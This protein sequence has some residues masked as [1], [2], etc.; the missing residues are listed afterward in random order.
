MLQLLKDTV[1][2]ARKPLLFGFCGALGCLASSLVGEVFLKAT[3]RP[4]TVQNSQS[5]QAVVMVIDASGSMYEVISD[6]LQYTGRTYISDGREVREVTGGRT[7]LDEVKSAAT[8]FVKRQN[9]SIAETKENQDQIAVISFGT[10]VQMTS[11]LTSNLRQIEGA[12]ESVY[13]GGGTRIDQGLVAA[14]LEL[15]KTSLTKNLLLFTD[16]IAESP[17][18]TIKEAEIIKSEGINLIAIATGGAD[19]EF[20]TELTGDENKVFFV[21]NGNFD[22]AFQEAEKVIYGKQLVESGETGDYGIVFGT[23]RIAGW[24][25]ILAVGV[26]LA[27]IIGQNK[28][29]RRRLLSLKEA[30]TGTIS[31]VMAGMIAGGV[32]QLVFDTASAT[33]PVL[34]TGGQFLGWLILGT[35]LGGGISF[36]V[37]NLK[38]SRGLLGGGIG[39]VLGGASFLLITNLSGA[40]TARLMGSAIIGFCI[41]VMIALLEILSKDARLI[42]HWNETEKREI[43]LGSRAIVL[44]Y[45]DSADVYLKKDQ[46]YFPV[47]ARIIKENEQIIMEFDNE[48][49]QSKGLKITRQELKDGTKRKLGDVT[50]E[51]KSFPIKK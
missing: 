15:S 22:T 42:I 49:V 36:F 46:G 38:K 45:A 48:Y 26:S 30:S 16:G 39:G 9:L 8:K 24:T 34:A 12:I 50:L 13:D 4:P 18:K 40:L 3:Y 27:L 28:Y 20:L 47:T 23:L 10:D 35:L 43:L 11:P 44:G 6:N 25:G 32:G 1:N 7:K 37:P 14:R 31:S 41:G 33:I 19:T 29:Q 2:Q 21:N 5:P 17:E 51:V